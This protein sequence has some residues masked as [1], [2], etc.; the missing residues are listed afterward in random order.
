MNKPSVQ[1][2]VRKVRRQKPEQD[3]YSKVVKWNT[4]RS[5]LNSFRAYIKPAFI[6]H[7]HYH[8]VNQLTK[9]LNNE[10]I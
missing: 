5:Q 8:F 9:S 10:S 7:I 6:Y 1:R 2:V 4:G 3:V